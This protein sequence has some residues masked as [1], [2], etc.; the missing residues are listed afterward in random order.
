MF[1]RIRLFSQ[2]ELFSP[3]SRPKNT[4]GSGLPEGGVQSGAA[5]CVY[6]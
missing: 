4:A 2:R 6:S 1:Q 3:T 5:G